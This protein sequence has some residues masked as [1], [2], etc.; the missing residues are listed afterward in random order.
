MRLQGYSNED[1]CRD[2]G[3]Y[4]RKIRR[5]VERLRGLAEQEG[6]APGDAKDG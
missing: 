1:I 3:I 2:L 5:V 4:D 6:W